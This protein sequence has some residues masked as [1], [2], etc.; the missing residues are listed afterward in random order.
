MCSTLCVCVW[1]CFCVLV[2]VCVCVC[3]DCSSLSTMLSTRPVINTHH[4]L[5][6]H[7][8][9]PWLALWCPH[10]QTALV[11]AA[12]VVPPTGTQTKP[13]TLNNQLSANSSHNRVNQQSPIRKSPSLT[14]WIIHRLKKIWMHAEKKGRHQLT[15]L[16]ENLNIGRQKRRDKKL[17][18]ALG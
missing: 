13:C 5:A 2:C 7:V 10:L 9:H 17:I 6:P 12:E 1:V 16:D 11:P 18:P 8:R 3:E 4:I 14:D 15:H